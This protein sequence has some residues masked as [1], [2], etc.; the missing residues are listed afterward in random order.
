MLDR[1]LQA[2]VL[3]KNPSLPQQL[4]AVRLDLQTIAEQTRLLVERVGAANQRPRS[5]DPIY[6]SLPYVS[7]TLLEVI[8][9]IVS[10]SVAGLYSLAIG[11][12]LAPVLSFRLAANTTLALALPGP[13]V[14]GRGL[15]LSIVPAGGA[16]AEGTII[17]IP[18]EDH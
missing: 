17:A 9:I 16:T 6:V 2:M 1:S 14:V 11:D 4:E 8:G 13:Y 10:G 5:P 7:S 18:R 12:N 15:T 3:V